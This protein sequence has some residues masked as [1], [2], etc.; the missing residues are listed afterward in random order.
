MYK[1]ALVGL[2]N[3][4]KSSL[5]NLLTQSNVLMA[6]Y[7]F[8]TVEPNKAMSRLYDEGVLALAAALG[9]VST[10]LPEVEV[11]DIAGLVKG[12]ADGEGLGNEFLGYIQQCDVLIHTVGLHDDSEQVLSDIQEVETEMALFDH[13][14]LL[15]YFEKA[16]RMARLYPGDKEHVRRDAVVTKAFYGSKKGQAVVDILTSEELIVVEDIGLVSAKPRLYVFN[17]FTN[18]QVSNTVEL[19]PNFEILQSN[20]LDLLTIRD[21]APDEVMELGYSVS[22]LHDFMKSLAER[23]IA[24][25]NL[26]RFYTV[27]HLGVG[28]WLAA[29]DSDAAEAS[30]ALHTE[31]SRA[32]TGVKVAELN[33]FIV[34]KSWQK[35]TKK[36]FVKKLGVKYIP[37]DRQ[38]LLFETN[39]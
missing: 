31:M 10:L 27:G 11:W 3:A 8:S 32:V 7:P 20:V 14:L 15:K 34:E 2:P 23:L 16:R 35:L 18:N 13:K 17:N 38:V 26:K 30:K 12:A 1:I 19:F 22:E 5:F 28:L 25:K 6:S 4:G 29:K 21:L 37:V 33:D 24:L 39:S 9:D 36:G